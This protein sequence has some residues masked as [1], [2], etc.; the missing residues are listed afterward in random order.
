MPPMCGGAGAGPAPGQFIPPQRGWLRTG[1]TSPRGA[2]IRPSS[3][4]SG[5]SL[6]RRRADDLLAIVRSLVVEDESF[7]CIGE[8]RLVAVEGPADV[9]CEELGDV[10]A[11]QHKQA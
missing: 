8:P 11:V 9:L 3:D 6:S 10:G 5:R 4:R 7:D 2:N 1:A